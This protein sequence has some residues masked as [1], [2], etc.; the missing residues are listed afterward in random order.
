V[1]PMDLAQRAT[2]PD[3]SIAAQARDLVDL[4]RRAPEKRTLVWFA[5]LIVGVI[6]LSALAQLWLNRWQGTFYDAIAQRDLPLF[7]RNLGLFVVIAGVL[8]V[9]GVAQTW[10]HENLKV[11]LRQAVTFD[12][13]DE[14][15]RPK[16]AYRLPLMGEIGSHPDQRIQDDARR[17]VELSV[18][19]GVGLVQSTLLLVCC[20]RRWFLPSARRGSASPAIWS[21]ARWPTR[22]WAP[23]SPGRSASR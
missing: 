22:S 12:L 2:A 5:G 15:L 14:W 16:R 9:L 4:L 6:V 1:L 13:I 20:R 8:L 7:Y 19:L 3:G 21:G 10:L 23:M 17:L 11:K 18:D